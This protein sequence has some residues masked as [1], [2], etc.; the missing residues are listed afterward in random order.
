MISIVAVTRPYKDTLVN[1]FAIMNET[2]L[3]IIGC[4]LFIFLDSEADD[5]V[6]KF[7]GWVIIGLVIC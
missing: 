3:F 1:I 7:Y 5:E 2:F 4:Y 6:L